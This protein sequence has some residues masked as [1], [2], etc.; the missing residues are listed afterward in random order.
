MKFTSDIAFRCIY[1][2][3]KA[4]KN[5]PFLFFARPS[6]HICREKAFEKNPLQQ[7]G[8]SLLMSESPIE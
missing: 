1:F 7:G 5:R 8:Q 6:L 3:K 2:K 4:R